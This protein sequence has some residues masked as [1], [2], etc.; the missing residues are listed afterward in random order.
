[1]QEYA[2]RRRKDT[3]MTEGQRRKIVI[4]RLFGRPKIEQLQRAA[5]RAGSRAE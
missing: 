1:L 3:S 4:S 2:L 5:V